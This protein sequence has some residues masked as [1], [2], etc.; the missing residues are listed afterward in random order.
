MLPRGHSPGIEEVFDSVGREIPGFA[1]FYLN[2]DGVLVARLVDRGEST[3]ARGF[4]RGIA[5]S[6][7]GNERRPPTTDVLIEGAE[8]D[9]VSLRSWRDQL[10]PFL[11]LA[12]VTGL[13]ANEQTNRVWVGVASDGMR[14]LMLSKIEE[15]GIP[16]GAVDVQQF[17]SP[18]PLATLRD[19]IRPLPGGMQIAVSFGRCTMTVNGTHATHGS[20]FVTCSHCTTS[21]G[22]QDST[23]FFQPEFLSEN[24][25][26][27]VVD[28]PLFTGAPCPSGRVCG[29]ADAAFIKYHIGSTGEF[30]RIAQPAARCTSN[31]VNSPLL[32][33][34]TTNPRWEIVVANS[35][36]ITSGAGL[37]KV[38]RTTGWTYG[39]VTNTCYD[40]NDPLSNTTR[41]CQVQTNGIAGPGDS[42]SP[43]FRFVAGSGPNKV[44]L[45]GILFAGNPNTPSFV[46][47]RWS[48][49]VNSLGA[50]STY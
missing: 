49:V 48:D 6:Q 16:L 39:I 44:S 21:L 17:E 8:Y 11:G 24:I 32:T 13:D 22:I 41:L 47:S 38:G 10:R 42:G 27:E 20:G 23:M 43:V 45:Y 18:P 34:S 30:A 7:S 25:G 31:C 46:F 15:L 35:G 37:Q 9:F 40:W 3:K 2:K 19:S 36:T 26:V 14:S 5:M 12:G 28:A 4:L 1:G 50:I 29:A 33:I